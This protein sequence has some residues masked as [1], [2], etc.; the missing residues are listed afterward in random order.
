MGANIRQ[1]C[2]FSKF[3][4]EKVPCFHFI[5]YL[6]MQNYILMNAMIF[7]AGLGTRLRPLTDDRPKAL[8]EVNGTSLLEHNILKLKN[9]GFDHIVVNVHHFGDLIIDFLRA[10]NNFGI[11]IQVSDERGLLLDTGGGLRKALPMFSNDEPI[12]VHNV[13][14]VCDVDLHDV[15]VVGRRQMEEAR[16]C[17]LLLVNDRKTSRYLLFDDS[18]YL[19]GWTNVQT[20]EVKG[21]MASRQLAFSG[22]HLVSPSISSYINMYRESES[23]FPIMDFYL[24]LCKKQL[25]SSVQLP[26][27]C[28][29]VDCGKIESL[30]KAADLLARNNTVKLV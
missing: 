13:D 1:S 30:S 24:D 19:R 29:W 12:L 9:S 14:I 17:A 16:C 28:G 3:L 22:I 21:Q 2:R 26:D 6:C 23:P 18:N 4:T 15:Y 20:G 8:V 10:N 25:V 11:D 7:A 27:S 5:S